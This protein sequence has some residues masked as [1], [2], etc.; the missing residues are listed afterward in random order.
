M[1]FLGSAIN[2]VTFYSF[3]LLKKCTP[4]TKARNESFLI[5]FGSKSKMVMDLS[6][7]T[8]TGE[9]SERITE[10]PRAKTKQKKKR[11]LRK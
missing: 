10:Q 1:Y 4:K 11:G 6:F 3:I 5:L 8:T 7:S 2:I 9:R